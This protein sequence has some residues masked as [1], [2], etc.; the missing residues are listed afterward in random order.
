M[1]P[2]TIVYIV[3]LAL[4]LVCSSFF[5]MSE[6]AFTSASI[7]RLKTM[8]KD[9]DRGAEKA[10][11]VLEDY[12]RLLTTILI[13]NNLVNIAATTIA[14]LFFVLLL[15]EATGSVVSTVVMT[16]LVLTFGEITP[17]TLAKRHPERYAVRIVGVLHGLEVLL[18]PVSWVFGKLTDRLSRKAGEEDAVMMTEDE[19]EVMI[20]EIEGDGVIEKAKGDLIKSAMRFDDTTV[21]EVFM[22]RVDVVAMDVATPP[23]EA[24]RV[25]SESGFSRIPVYNG[26]IDNIVGVVNAKEFYSR[27]LAGEDFSLSDIANPVKY[28]PETMSIDAVFRDFQK[29]KVHMAVVLDSY[30]GTMGIVTMEDI[31]EELVGEIWDESDDVQQDIVEQSDGTWVVKGMSSIFDAMEA[32]GRDFDPG[33]YDD[34]SVSGY[35]IYRLNRPPVRGDVVEVGD[36]RIV[37]NAVKGRRAVECLFVR[38]PAAQDGSGEPERSRPVRNSERTL[39]ATSFLAGWACTLPVTAITSPWCAGTYSPCTAFC[40]SSLR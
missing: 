38:T 6:T 5:S 17:K 1:D 24:G 28:V 11:A 31:L 15:G 33:E 20:D 27:R 30:G 12:D 14:A 10:V 29:T 2:L 23:E 8:A 34:H 16:I 7:V 26:S 32:V 18:S 9:G 22:P 35:V 13:G 40:L 21:S 3:I 4:L 37:V 25:F 19:L 36:V 39:A